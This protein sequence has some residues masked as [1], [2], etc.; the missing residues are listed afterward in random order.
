MRS[1]IGS[2]HIRIILCA[3]GRKNYSEN[4]MSQLEIMSSEYY[5]QCVDCG[6]QTKDDDTMI[7]HCLN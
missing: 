1:K 7:D 5:F 6:F 2:E 4:R 3:H